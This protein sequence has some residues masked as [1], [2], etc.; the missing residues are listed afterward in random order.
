[1][2]TVILGFL[3][4]VFSLSGLF[5]VDDFCSC[6]L[7]WYG[8][9]FVFVLGFFVVCLFSLVLFYQKEIN[10]GVGVGKFL[11]VT[12]KM[13][14]S[15][16]HLNTDVHISVTCWRCITWNWAPQVHILIVCNFL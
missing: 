1:M 11:Q 15:G 7:I 3:A 5:I 2:F 12:F 10:I 9:S 13:M 16:P 4:F 6:S 14:S 8:F